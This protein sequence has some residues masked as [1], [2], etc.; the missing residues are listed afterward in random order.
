MQ[1]KHIT[2]FDATSYLQ[3]QE[4]GPQWL[5]PLCNGPAPYSSL[6]VDEY[7]R[8]ILEQTSES[9]EQV[10]IEPDGSWRPQSSDQGQRSNGYNDYSAKV[11]DD[12]DLLIISN[13]PSYSGGFSDSFGTPMRHLATDS[14]TPNGGS[15]EPVAQPR[16]VGG[17]K[18]TAEVIDLTFSSDDDEPVLRPAKRQNVG[19]EQHISALPFPNNY[20]L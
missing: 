20:Q 18:R 9:E 10:T 5:C 4:Q 12:D 1:C 7:A 8:E 15:R 19:S 17:T 14:S 16:S 11:E 13:A 3:L 2:C 6:A